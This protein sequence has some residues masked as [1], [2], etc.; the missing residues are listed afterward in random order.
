MKSLEDEIREI[1]QRLES[2]E[3]TIQIDEYRG[4]SIPKHSPLKKIAVKSS[5]IITNINSA[6]IEFEKNPIKVL[7]IPEV[8][9][10]LDEIKMALI[11]L[12]DN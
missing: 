11:Q 2:I 5:E 3:R 9:S 7:S 10:K 8:P 6:N 12:E 4:V 1:R